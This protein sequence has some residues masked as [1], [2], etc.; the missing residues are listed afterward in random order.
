[1]ARI[2]IAKLRKDHKMS[3]QQL[4]ERLQIN[5]SFLSAIERGK[6]P[7][8]AGKQERISEIFGVNDFSAYM[9]DDSE[10][11]FSSLSQDSLKNDMIARMLGYF[12]A[13]AH[14]EIDSQY[15]LPYG[16][17]HDDADS[18]HFQAHAQV[19]QEIDRF[20]ADLKTRNEQLESRNILLT[21]RNEMLNQKIMD[22][23]DE[24][25]AL[26]QENYSLKERL[27]GDVR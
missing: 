1:M 4:A 7:L 3:Q 26:R 8:P 18:A 6:S 19:H 21:E 14:Q 22:L 5:Q 13:R 9:V 20:F 16:H 23:L 17:S 12:H 15:G 24:L 2:D 27:L 11:V 25:E 10:G